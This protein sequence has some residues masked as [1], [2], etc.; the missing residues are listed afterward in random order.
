[1]VRKIV[2]A[3][4]R[5]LLGVEQV[6]DLSAIDNRVGKISS[7]FICNSIKRF[8]SEGLFFPIIF[9]KWIPTGDQDCVPISLDR[10]L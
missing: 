10:V 3:L 5:H 9:G 6:I 2:S 4:V 8:S 7:V 1:M